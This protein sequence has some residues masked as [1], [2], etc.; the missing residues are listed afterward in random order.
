MAHG[1]LRRAHRRENAMQQSRVATSAA[2]V[3][4]VALVLLVLGPAL[5]MSGMVIPM[6]GFN[7]FGVGALLSVLALALGLLGLVFTRASTGATGRGRA[8]LAIGVGAVALGTIL[9]SANPDL[10]PINDITTNTDDPPQF[11][12]AAEHAPNRGRDMSYPGE[13]FAAAQRPAYPDLTPIAIAKPTGETF[14]AV[15]RAMQQ[16]GWEI[17]RRDRAT[18]ALEA[19]E[20]SRIFRFVDDVVVRIRPTADGA[21]VDIRSKSRDGRGDLGANAARIRRLRDAITG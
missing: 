20:T 13:S 12:A 14:D 3:A 21:S 16:L 4:I 10:P 11:V 7:T 6:V 15:D 17:T 19:S 18:G 5:T 8:G 9:S 1:N 2:A